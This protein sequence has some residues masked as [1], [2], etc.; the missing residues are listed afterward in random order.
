MRSGLLV[1]KDCM[2]VL[3]SW[4]D[5]KCWVLPERKSLEFWVMHCGEC[6]RLELVFSD[7]LEANAC[8]VDGQ[9]PNAVLLKVYD[10]F[11]FDKVWI[12]IIGV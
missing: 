5:V 11:L 1:D 9:E 6:Y 2:F 7:V 4:G 10:L 8:C 3:E 12:F